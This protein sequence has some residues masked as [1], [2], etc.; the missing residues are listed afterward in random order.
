MFFP[1]GFSYSR[2]RMN[3]ASSAHCGV[4]LRLI[5]FGCD[6]TYGDNTMTARPNKM[7]AGLAERAP[8]FDTMPFEDLLNLRQQLDA[9]IAER[10][11]AE[12]KELEERLS[13]LKQ[14]K[15]PLAIP[16]VDR[17]S[18][19]SPSPRKLP[20]RYRN[21]EDPSQAWAGRGLQPRWL[22]QALKSGKKLSYFLVEDM[23]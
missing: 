7:K 15:Q 21:P 8:Q 6:T 5:A 22:K 16:S 13:R 1:P 19:E 23:E 2:M 3:R 9:L 14:L 17:E 12:E 10:I 18:I 4:N 11:G 20:I